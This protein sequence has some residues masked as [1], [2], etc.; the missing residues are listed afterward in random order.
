MI[1]GFNGGILTNPGRVLSIENMEYYGTIGR[2][3][4]ESAGIPVGLILNEINNMEMVQKGIELGFNAVMFESV[5]NNPEENISLTKKIVKIAHAAG[6]AVESNV[7]TLPTAGN[8][9][10][11]RQCATACLTTPGGAKR[12]VDRTGVDMLGVSIGNIEVLM[13]GKA[14]IDLA[15]LKAIHEATPVYLTLHGGSGIA[16]E[17]VKDL[18]ASGLCKMNLG[19]AL[20]QA[21]ID[22]IDEVLKSTGQEVSAKYRIGSGLKE[23]VMAG[24]EITMKELVRHKMRVY[25]SAGK[26]ANPKGEETYRRAYNE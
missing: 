26:A 2:I 19:A 13:K 24:G 12:F 18:I 20:N 3:A 17:D 14:T 25:G 22:G 23:D 10:L 5:S 6:V 8:G 11:Q 15:L 16:D 1:I 21:F 7:G 9:G 4:A